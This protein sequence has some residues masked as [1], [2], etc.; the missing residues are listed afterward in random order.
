MLDN[1]KDAILDAPSDAYDGISTYWDSA[2]NDNDNNITFEGRRNAI[3][4]GLGALGAAAVGDALDVNSR[5]YSAGAT[6]VGYIPDMPDV[7]IDVQ[8][9]GSSNQGGGSGT[10]TETTPEETTDT[11]TETETDTPTPEPHWTE[12]YGGRDFSG[13]LVGMGQAQANGTADLFEEAYDNSRGIFDVE[14]VDWQ[15]VDTDHLVQDF[16]NYDGLALKVN[17]LAA[18]VHDGTPNTDVVEG[19]GYSGSFVEDILEPLD[20]EEELTRVGTEYAEEVLGL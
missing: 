16:E 6:A 3:Q 5:A 18:P 8:V 9:G 4:L 14:L 17:N 13:D 19:L 11:P 20:D 7:S 12:S 1:W 10:P 15:D 2:R